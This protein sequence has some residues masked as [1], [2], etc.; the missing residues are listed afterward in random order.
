MQQLTKKLEAAEKEQIQ[1]VL[2]MDRLQQTEKELKEARNLLEQKQRELR[3]AW[4]KGGEYQDMA[5][6]NRGHLVEA[7]HNYAKMTSG[8][9][10]P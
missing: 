10:R 1:H 5:V 6:L 4:K 8:E 7:D 3:D 2:D 9:V